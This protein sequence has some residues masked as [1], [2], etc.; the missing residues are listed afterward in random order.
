MKIQLSILAASISLAATGMAQA[1]GPIDGKV[2]GKV[3]LTLQSSDEGTDSRVTEL[4]SNA[5]RLG[6]KGETS[7]NDDL[8]VIYQLEYEANFDDGDKGGRTITQ[9]D[10]FAG[11]KGG[12]GTV[13]AG[14]FNTPTKSA[15]NKVDL[16]SDYVGDIKNVFS[17]VLKVHQR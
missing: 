14:I 9:R 12:F 7:L 4:V 10:S 3:N 15:Q 2:Y 17:G 13:K 11:L 1:E 8:S 16:F 5:S 6:F